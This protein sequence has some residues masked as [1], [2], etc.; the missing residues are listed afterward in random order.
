MSSLLPQMLSSSVTR[1]ALPRP[2][3]RSLESVS[4]SGLSVIELT[5]ARR[6]QVLSLADALGFGANAARCRGSSPLVPHRT[7][8]SIRYEKGSPKRSLFGNFRPVVSQKHRFQG[9][10]LVSSDGR[11]TG[12]RTRSVVATS[13]GERPEYITT[14]TSNRKQQPACAASPTG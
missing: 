7:L 11:R 12:I 10:S 9:T 5:T 13:R 8:E 3:R 4:L 1:L 2:R 14:H 6:T